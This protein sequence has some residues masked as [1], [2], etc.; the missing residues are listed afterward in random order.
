MF[1]L[2]SFQIMKSSARFINLARGKICN[3]KDL[4][5]AL[6]Q[7]LIAMALLDVTEPEPLPQ[8]HHL[9]H[10]DNC[11]IFPH[12]ATNTLNS[13]IEVCDVAVQNIVKIL[14]SKLG[15]ASC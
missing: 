8:N 14:F 2:K 4:Y 12:I 11:L 1:D 9:Y 15:E 13:R 3:H 5:I 7:G 10:L 6:K